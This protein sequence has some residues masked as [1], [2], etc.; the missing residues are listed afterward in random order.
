MPGDQPGRVS[1]ESTE[2]SD[3][4]LNDQAQSRADDRI[5]GSSYPTVIDDGE[6]KYW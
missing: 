6:A 2:V 4:E 1:G 3:V 5:Y